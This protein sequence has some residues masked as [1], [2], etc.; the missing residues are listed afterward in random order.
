MSTPPSIS[1][2]D[3][4]GSRGAS[5]LLIAVMLPAAS[6]V[7]AKRSNSEP[8][9]ENTIT[10]RGGTVAARA[11]LPTIASSQGSAIAVP[12][13]PRS[14]VRRDS[15]FT[16]APSGSGIRRPGSSPA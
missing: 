8:L 3:L 5:I 4:N 16:A 10:S 1:S 6:V 7:G 2:L 12:P 14:T 15:G 9:A 13:R 11:C